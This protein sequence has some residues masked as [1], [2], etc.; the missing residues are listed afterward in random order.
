MEQGLTPQIRK[1]FVLNSIIL[2]TKSQHCLSFQKIPILWNAQDFGVMK[3][4]LLRT[5]GNTVP[6]ESILEKRN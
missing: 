2:Y 1:H 6:G 3:E 4:K 5:H